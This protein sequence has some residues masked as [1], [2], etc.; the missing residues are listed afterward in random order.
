[1][2]QASIDTFARLLFDEA[3]AF[4]EKGHEASGQVSKNGH[5]HASLLLGFCS[6]EAHVNSIAEEFHDRHDVTLLDKAVLLERKIILLN[7]RHRLTEDL[8][9]FRLEDRIQFLFDKFSRT[10][11][12]RES[13]M[14][15]NLKGALKLRNQLTHPK[16]PPLVSE[17]SAED[18]LK[19][20][21]EML[22]LLYKGIYGRPYP[23]YNYGITAT[24]TL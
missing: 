9:I 4:F 21:L 5:F 1:M 6:L 23:D 18:A 14:W 16:T 7:G 15:A 12:D 11:L 8:Q 13:A 3:K 19:A 17:R 2:K 10:P 20:I 24:L 22:N